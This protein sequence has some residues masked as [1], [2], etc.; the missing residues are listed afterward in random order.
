M[1]EYLLAGL[2]ELRASDK[3]PMTMEAL[4]EELKVCL[5]E[6]DQEQL[7]LLDH[8]A[9]YG[10]YPFIREWYRF[11]RV[12][13]NTLVIAICRHHGL[14]IRLHTLSSLESEDPMTEQFNDEL[15]RVSKIDDLYER[16]RA[17]DNL[18]F[19]WLEE[20]TK[21][22]NFSFENVVAY[23]LELQMLCRWDKLTTEE[24]E[25]VFREIVQEMKK[26]IKLDTI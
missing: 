20:A 2:P 7:R 24:G 21:L 11:E 4:R 19:A 5:T 6:Q 16:E 9:V 25:K 15:T 22:K 26:G 17:I 18:R 13:N 23:Y 12:L 1:Y 10:A 3:A 14:D 8:H